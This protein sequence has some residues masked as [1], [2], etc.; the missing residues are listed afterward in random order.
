MAT[1]KPFHSH[2]GA[3]GWLE[4]FAPKATEVSVVIVQPNVRTRKLQTLVVT[5]DRSGLDCGP[6]YKGDQGWSPRVVK[7]A[8]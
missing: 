4:Q 2:L 6:R 7:L 5:F 3:V 1:L 8:K